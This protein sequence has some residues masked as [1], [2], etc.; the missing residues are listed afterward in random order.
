MSVDPTKPISSAIDAKIK[1]VLYSGKNCSLDWVP[2]PKPLPK[3]SP[4]PT[5]IV[6]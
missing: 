5:A 4:D 1:S 3:N 6:D 2:L